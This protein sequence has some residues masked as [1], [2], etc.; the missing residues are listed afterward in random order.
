VP[1]PD[2]TGEHAASISKAII[3]LP[4]RFGA[5]SFLIDKPV[6]SFISD[7]FVKSAEIKA[8]ESRGVLTGT[9]Q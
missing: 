6:K 4:Q 5:S 7:G 2:P 8:C 1:T 9:P 3:Q